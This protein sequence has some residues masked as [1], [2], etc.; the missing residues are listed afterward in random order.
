MI[1]EVVA[2]VAEISAKVGEAT[3]KVAEASKTA[4][5]I[6]KRIDVTEKVAEKASN[7]VDISKRITPEGITEKIGDVG[8]ELTAKQKNELLRNGMSEGIVNKCTFDNGIYKLKTGYEKLEGLKQADSGV[9]YAKKVIDFAGAKLEGVFPQ[10]ESVFTA[11]LP[12]DKL[13]ASDLVQFKECI[14]QL[15]QALND[16][17]ALKQQFSPRQ[18]EQIANGKK[19]SGYVWHHNEEVGKMELVDAEKHDAAKHV[20]GKAIWGGGSSLR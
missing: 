16:N 19:P 3:E 17:P 4:T 14:T 11:Q 20:G 2:T 9:S 6:G 12:A 15:Q 7:G 10:F 18:L 8:K 13:M 5:D 1:S